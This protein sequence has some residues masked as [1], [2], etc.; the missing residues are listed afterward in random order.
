MTTRKEQTIPFVNLHGHTTFSIFDGMGYPKDHMDFAYEN[1]SDALAFTDHGNMNALSYQVIHAKK[2]KAEG[3][4]FKPIFGIEAYFIDDID[5]WKKEYEESTEKKKKKDFGLSIEDEAESKRATRNILSRRAHLVLLAQNQKGLENLFELVSKS[6]ERENFYRYPRIDYKMLEEHSEGIICSTACLSGPLSKDYWNNRELGAEAVKVAMRAT[7]E[8]FKG[9]FGDSFYGELQ[10]NGIPEQHDVNGYIIDVCDELGIELVSTADSHYPRPEL[11]KDRELY[12]QIG[13][14]GKTKP[15]YMNSKLPETRE[16]LKYELYPKNGDEMYASFLKY[17]T[18][19]DRSYDSDL[20]RSSITR[21][22]DIAHNKIEDFYPNDE[23]NLPSWVAGKKSDVETLRSFCFEGLKGKNLDNE[24]YNER[25]EKELEV[26]ETRGFAKYFLTMKAISDKA[27]EVQLVGP[28]RGSAAGSLISYVLKITQIDPIKHGLLFERFLTRDGKGYPDIDYDV[29]D[30]MALKDLFIKEWGKENVVPISNFNT[31]QFRSLIKDVSKFYDIP[32][33]EVNNITN[34][35]MDEATPLAKQKHNIKAGVYTPTFEELCEFSHSLKGFF[36]KYPQIKDHVINLIGQVRSISRHAGGVL[37]ADDLN[38]KMP[39]I[40]SGGVVQTPWTEGQNVRHLEPFGF[41]KFDILGLASLRMIEGAIRHILVRH[42]GI[43]SPTFEDVRQFYDKHLHPD[44]MNLDD[45]KIYKDIFQKGKWAGIF[46]FT[47]HGA[48]TFCKEA[49][50]K[51]LIDL[52]AITSIFRPGPLSANVHNMYVAAKNNPTGIK[53]LTKEVKE[54]T[55]DTYGF[56]IFQEQIALLAH[57]LGKDLSLDEGNMLRKVLTKKGTGKEAKVKKKLHGKF[58]AGCVEKKIEKASAEKLWQ[59]FEYFSGYGFNK[60]HAVSYSA[61]S[62]QCAWLFHNYPAE[63]MAA[64]LDKEPEDRKAKAISIART[65]G[66]KTEL[67]SINTSADVWE[68]S[69]DGKTLYQPLTS[70]KGLGIKAIEQVMNHR[71]FNTIEEFLFHKEISYGKLNKKSIDVLVRSHAL[72]ELIDDR[73]TG[74]KHFWSSVAVD[75]PRNQKKL[76][77][78]IETYVGEKDFTNEEKIQYL[79]A[80]TGVYPVHMVVDQGLLTRFENMKVPPL[81]EY[82]K[83]LKIAWFIPKEVISKK[84]KNGKVYWMVNVTDSSSKIISI[85]C[86]G[87]NPDKDKV[88]LNKPYFG[89][90]DYSE[91]WGFSTRSLY[92]NFKLL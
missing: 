33:M 45:A 91:K 17:S 59:T 36:N 24:E 23:V 38:K 85:K 56:L 43:E 67:P 44:V 25:L 63:W 71:P 11:F 54:I 70:I 52:S 13:W 7:C 89:K 6:Y 37:I 73:F 49:K 41:I 75:R 26:I 3:K 92:H 22:H 50:P 1:G 87:V 4:K 46:Q 21:T 9:I 62:F 47:N 20:V 8:R 60:S 15:D 77:E 58:I 72:N 83:A 12:K 16:D 18:D 2:M 19:C 27:Q 68:I 76:D 81:G 30:P 69:E 78:N 65:L 39:L 10:W 28:G 42:E 34:K 31:L 55:K 14:L 80:L 5:K 51:N 32:F 82:D 64:F 35:M 84:T 74:M 57:R 86:W 40:N 48:Q 66:F 79:D 53:Y 90:L 88:E 61:L 29:A